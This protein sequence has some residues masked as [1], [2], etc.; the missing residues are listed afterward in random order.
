MTSKEER[1]TSKWWELY[2]FII[3]GIAAALADY[4][5]AQ[6]VV[7]IANNLDDTWKIVISTGFGFIVG[8]IVNYFISTYWVYQNVDK[9][10]NS[11]SP[12]FIILFVLLSLVAMFLS[13]GTMLLCNLTFTSLWGEEASTVK[14]SLMSLIKEFG[15]GFLGQRIFWTYFA[16]FCL[17]TLVG[18]VF[19]YFTRKYILYKKPKEE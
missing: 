8:V 10:V 9:S 17:K 3:C 18:L 13:M 1:K 11:K 15:M 4:L 5:T 14:V 6:L 7:L 19:N 2:R 12:K 16:P